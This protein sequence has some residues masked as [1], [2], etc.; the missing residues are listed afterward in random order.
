ML[1]IKIKICDWKRKGTRLK[2]MSNATKMSPQPQKLFKWAF[3]H[4][5]V[6]FFKSI[7][8]NQDEMVRRCLLYFLALLLFPG[9]GRP[10]LTPPPLP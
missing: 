3:R 1:G 5:Y 6:T 9:R 2:K 8:K 4:F 7:F 10:F